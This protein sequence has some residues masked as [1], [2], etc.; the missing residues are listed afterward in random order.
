[1]KRK[2]YVE[3]SMVK[4]GKF[5]TLTG[6]NRGTAYEAMFRKMVP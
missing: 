1:M 3:P 6:W 5:R 2:P 4:V